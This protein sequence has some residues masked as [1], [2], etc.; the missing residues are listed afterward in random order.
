ML[1]ALS[2]AAPLPA[3]KP[4]VFSKVAMLDL[5]II[6]GHILPIEKIAYQFRSWL[7]GADSLIQGGKYTVYFDIPGEKHYVDK[8]PVCVSGRAKFQKCTALSRHRALRNRQRL[9]GRARF[10]R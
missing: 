9:S 10:P 5:K 8:L 1:P 3:D 4:V 7:A 2:I 6:P